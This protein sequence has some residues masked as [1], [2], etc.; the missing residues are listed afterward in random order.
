MEWRLF[1]EG[2][3]P[4]CST[5]PF[6]AA[7][8]W[9]PPEAQSGHAE[10]TAM[11]GEIV[12]DLAARNLFS[13]LSDLGCGDGRFLE[14]VSDLPVRAWGYDAGTANIAKAVSHGVDARRADILNDPL[15]YGDLVTACEVIEH[16]ADP[17]AFVASLPGSMIVLSSPSAE[18]D[19]WYYPDHTWA[20][21]LDGYAA[22]VTGAGWT[23]VR[24][25][26]CD[27]G[28]NHHFGIER[29]QRFQAVY[30]VRGDR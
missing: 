10:R 3:M 27:G 13:S 24:H 14:T 26:E 19:T 4:G 5:V 23:V 28:V 18:D 22:L 9:T 20:W 1:A 29:P 2:T 16:L 15:E 17:H 11:V 6:F 21:D 12:R 8:P 7:H 30:A 25:D